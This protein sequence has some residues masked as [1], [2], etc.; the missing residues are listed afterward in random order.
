MG[1]KHVPG[2][3]GNRCQGPTFRELSVNCEKQPCSGCARCFVC[4]CALDPPPQKP[5][6]AASMI[7]K[8]SKAQE[9]KRQHPMLHLQEA[10]KLCLQP[11]AKA[12]IHHHPWLHPP[13]SFFLLPLCQQVQTPFTSPH[14][15]PRLLWTPLEAASLACALIPPLL[16]ATSASHRHRAP[17][18]CPSGV[19]RH[20]TLAFKTPPVSLYLHVY[21]L[22]LCSLVPNSQ[23]CFPGQPISM[24]PAPLHVQNHPKD[25]TPL[26]PSQCKPAP[27]YRNAN[28]ITAP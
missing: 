25:I 11:N 7:A 9:G 28:L 27:C 15:F 14:S 2:P 24:L 18:T 3:A 1:S 4:I 13:H 26:G 22:A 16:L 23:I 5:E 17:H 19:P 10:A 21:I 6:A 20:T 12:H 8:E